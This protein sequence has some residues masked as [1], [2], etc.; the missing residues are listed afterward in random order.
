M[1]VGR[2]GQG[3]WVRDVPHSSYRVYPPQEEGGGKLILHGGM[4]SLAR[5][6]FFTKEE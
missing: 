2:R 5:F 3:K 6:L 1:E 4:T